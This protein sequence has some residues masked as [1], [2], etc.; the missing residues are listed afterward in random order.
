LRLE[1]LYLVALVL[2]GSQVVKPKIMEPSSACALSTLETDNEMRRVIACVALQDIALDAAEKIQRVR[3]GK[4][5]WRIDV[6]H[7]FLPALC[8]VEKRIFRRNDSALALGK[9][10]TLPWFCNPNLTL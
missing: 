2:R 10:A 6:N 5:Q 7:C 8:S 3:I 9:I 4:I 1:R